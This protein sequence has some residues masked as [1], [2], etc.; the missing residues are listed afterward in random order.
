MSKDFE[1]YLKRKN[2]AHIDI[3]G[4]D[5]FMENKVFTAK[6]ICEM[7]TDWQN[8]FY[9]NRA[10]LTEVFQDTLKQLSTYG[11]AAPSE[12]KFIEDLVDNKIDFE[13]CQLMHEGI[14]KVI[15]GDCINVARDISPSGRT[16]ILNMA[17]A[18]KPGGGVLNGA[19]AQ[20]EE[21]CR[22]SNLYCTLDNVQY[23]LLYDEYAYSEAVSFF[24]DEQYG[25][26]DRFKCD[27]I[28]IAALN[29]NSKYWADDISKDYDIIMR[30]KIR[31]M[32]IDPHL[33][34]C[35]NLVLSAFGCGV[36]K[37]DPTEVAK[38]FKEELNNY[39]CLYNNVI[40]AI[41]NDHNSD[42]DNYAIFKEILDDNNN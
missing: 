36:F 4:E 15:E 28:T 12:K 3:I 27:V 17:S 35:T 2:K 13:Q 24:K 9:E 37:N 42:N 23:P 33:H 26:I 1:N 18:K 19:R 20:E 25:N 41:Y 7:V 30:A 34:K 5:D 29:K 38:I 21:L 14:V 16:C 39:K 40:F 31:A 22:R 11:Y 6:E 10:M 8:E 32:L